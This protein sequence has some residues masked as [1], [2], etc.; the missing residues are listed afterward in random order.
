LSNNPGKIQI[1]TSVVSSGGPVFVIAEAGVNHN[2]DVGIAKRMIDVAKN[3][4]ADAVKFQTFKAESLVTFDAPK[5]DYQQAT[6]KPGES[7]LEMLRKLE[8]SES[9]HYILKEHCDKTGI[10]FLST[11]FDEASADF[12]EGLKIPAYKLSSGD[13][14]NWPLIEH[15]ARKGKPLIISTGMAT[16]DEV[17]EAV[18]TA[19]TAGCKELVLLHCVSNYPAA[20]AE[21]NLRAMAT[22]QKQFAIPV[23]YSDHTVGI[24]VSLAAVALGAAVIEKHFTLDR[25][26]PG[27]DHRASLEPFELESLVQGI[28]EVEVSLGSG[29]KGP[30]ASEL[31]TAKVA[32]RSIVAASSIQCGSVLQR[33]SLVMK[34]PGTGLP[35][36]MLKTL[37]GKRARTD[38]PA[39]TLI[40]L[41][42]LD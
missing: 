33:E 41:E 18:C 8:L 32:R 38:I 5:A 26:L 36:S 16:L 27:P 25:N 35:P 12:L 7:Q 22:M 2:G 24:A 42:M 1:G 37:L 29:E 30:S 11:P 39:G 6:T 21:T 10:I 14:T 19:T 34:R 3:A 23:G 17:S 4:G 13:L 15:L 9:A 31:E 20:A 40:T 28:R